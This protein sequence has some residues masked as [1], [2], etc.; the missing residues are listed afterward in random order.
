MRL[1]L[2]RVGSPCNVPPVPR[3][4]TTFPQWWTDLPITDRQREKVRAH[5]SITRD[6]YAV[7]YKGKKRTLAKSIPVDDLAAAWDLKRAQIDAEAR[8]QEIILA[9]ALTYRE[10]LSEFLEVQKA[11]VGAARNA[12]EERTYHN[13]T[14]V[15]NDFGGFVHAGRKLADLAIRDIGPSHFSAFAEKFKGWKASGFDS[16]VS[17][18][19]AL[20]RWAVEMEY[21]DRY[22]PGP[23]FRRP[24]KSEIRSERIELTKSYTA[25]EVAKLYEGAPHVIRCWIALGICAA[26]NNSDIG[27]LPRKVVD[28]ETGVIDFRRRKTGKER[29]VIPLPPDVVTLLKWYVRP[30]PAIEEWDGLFFLTEQGNPYARSKSRDGAYKPSDSISR[31][32]ARLLES[33]E[34]STTADGRN[35]SGLR[36]THFN[37]APKDKWEFERKVVMGRAKGDIDLDHYLERLGVEDLR[38]YVQHIWDQISTAR[39]ETEACPF[40][41]TEPAR[42]PTA[43]PNTAAAESPAPHPSNSP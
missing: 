11:R 1:M 42:A 34:V 3:R 37:L 10:V 13:Y 4:Q 39:R 20:F 8:G 7:W 23:Q 32:F 41:S 26:F 19:G 31:L 36:T 22:R 21:I 5:F 14:T 43:S 35:F 24:D 6:G 28:L 27:N 30:E 25:A 38:K 33:A 15:L 18:V 29:R 2:T 17:R 12:I 9:T 16:V 40:A